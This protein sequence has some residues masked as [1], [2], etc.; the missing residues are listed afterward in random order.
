MRVSC[1]CIKLIGARFR[2]ARHVYPENNELAVWN[3]KKCV[4]M[5]QCVPILWYC[6]GNAN[7]SPAGHS[8]LTITSSYGQTMATGDGDSGI[9]EQ[10]L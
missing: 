4:N 3:T 10:Q 6:V 1:I 9:S 7:L 8:M 5:R 2:L